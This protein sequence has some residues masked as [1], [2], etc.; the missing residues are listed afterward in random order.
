MFMVRILGPWPLLV[1][2]LA[3]FRELLATDTYYY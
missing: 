2:N 1:S 3:E